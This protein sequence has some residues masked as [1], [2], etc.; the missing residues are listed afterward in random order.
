[1]LANGL[2]EKIGFTE[3]QKKLYLKYDAE[4]GSTV[5]D[6]SKEA[7]E[8]LE[9]FLPCAEKLREKLKGECHEFTSDLLFLLHWEMHQEY[10]Q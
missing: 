7:M 4:F 5:E 3:E 10:L 6:Y 2:L 1:M 9:Q 8:N